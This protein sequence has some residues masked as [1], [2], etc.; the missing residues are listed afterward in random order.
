MYASILLEFISSAFDLE[1]R[2]IQ[3]TVYANDKASVQMDN[4]RFGLP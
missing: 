2:S 1:H 3:D 4:L